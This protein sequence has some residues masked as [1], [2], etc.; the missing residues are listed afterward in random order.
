MF[1]ELRPWQNVRFTSFT[2]PMPMLDYREPELGAIFRIHDT[3]SQAFF[4]Q[5]KNED[6][7]HVLWNRSDQTHRFYVD[8]QLHCLEPNQICTLTYLNTVRTQGQMPLPFFSV[9]FNRSFYCILDHDDEVSCNGILFFGA[10]EFPLVNIPTEEKSSFELLHQVWLE[11]S[12]ERDSIQ[13]EMLRSLLKRYIIKV[14]RLARIQ[15]MRNVERKE[16]SDLIRR[17]NVLVDQYFREK[18]QV[19]DYAEL[20]HKSAKTLSNYFRLHYHKSPLEVIQDRQ[21]LEA[22]RL[23]LHSELSVKEVAW[24]IGLEDAGSLHRLF[25]HREL[26][27]PKQFRE[28]AKSGKIATT[29]GNVAVKQAVA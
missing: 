17:F 1:S 23:L 6:L 18:R 15:L 8:D 7:I 20:L 26:Q 14:T 24:Q 19:G 11:E 25:K 9:S 10:Q 5:S 3:F 16:Q 27:S 4:E 13:G 28:L 29:S 2:L 12:K 22:K 21:L